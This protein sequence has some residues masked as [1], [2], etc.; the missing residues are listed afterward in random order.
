MLKRL[1]ALSMIVLVVAA[2]ETTPEDTSATGASA[3]GGGSG[4]TGTSGI[5]SSGGYTTSG[6]SGTG[7][8]RGIPGDPAEV[9]RQIASTGDTVYFAF[10]SY[11]LDSSAQQALDR[12]AALL[13]KY[14]GITVTIEGHTDERGTREYNIALGD[15]RATAVR[16]YLVAYGIDAASIRTISYGEERPA[17]LGSSEAAWAKN[18]RGVTVVT[19][20]APSS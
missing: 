10:D 1:L 6:L 4:T 2:C 7:G 15:R 5:P 13:L 17:V 20:G 3:S 12:Q 16:D 18:R 19:G 9:E 14:T 11:S 8:Q